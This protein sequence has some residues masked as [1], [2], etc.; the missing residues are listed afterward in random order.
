M[1]SG[2][3]KCVVYDCLDHPNGKYRSVTLRIYQSTTDV[4]VLQGVVLSANWQDL[5]RRIADGLE[6]EL[7]VVGPPAER[8]SAAVPATLDMP[9]EYSVRK[10]PAA[11]VPSQLA[12]F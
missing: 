12:L 7:R 3:L 10:S 8:S 2:D 1:D 5:V 6:A 4:L 11:V 9:T